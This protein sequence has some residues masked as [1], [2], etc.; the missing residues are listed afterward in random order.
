M[1]LDVGPS[2][3]LVHAEQGGRAMDLERGLLEGGLVRI[4]AEIRDWLPVL[5]Q[6]AER[7]R[8]PE[9]L[10]EVPRRMVEAAQ[11][12]D[13]T[14]LTPM[15]AVAGAVADALMPLVL[16]LSPERAW[17]NNGGDL[18]V[19]A[20]GGRPIR[21]GIKDIARAEAPGQVL[22]VR[23]REAFGVATSGLGGRSF[24]LGVA[25]RGT[26]LARSGALAD[27]A[28]TLLCN[29]TAIASPVIV[30]EKASVLD[31]CTDIPE[32]CVTVR[33]GHLGG[34]EITEALARGLAASRGL[35][36]RGLIEGAFLVV[37]GKGASTFE[38]EGP[39]RLEETHAV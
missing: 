15:A 18:S 19:Y 5:R 34:E 25:Q 30:R 35:M 36:A 7:I 21:I 17:V 3:V 4:L 6:R 39:F 31:P 9:G 14:S 13:G 2:S 38:G 26:V 20:E 11:A 16:G 32:A 28:A 23:G 12:V 37:K 29:A 27:A 33:V 8:R 10:P 22:E 1:L 24:T